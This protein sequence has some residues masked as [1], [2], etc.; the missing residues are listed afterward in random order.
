MNIQQEVVTLYTIGHSNRSIEEFVEILR[1]IPINTLVDV[2]A[3]PQSQRYPQFSQESLRQSLG[4]AGITYH[5]A[6]KQLGAM[7]KPQRESKHIALKDENLRAYADYM[8]SEVFQ[9]AMVQLIH[10]ASLENTV[11]LC[12][13]KLPEH[14]HR[15]LISDYLLLQGVE[16]RH[17]LDEATIVSHQLNP[18]V[19]RES[20]QL[21]YDRGATKSLDL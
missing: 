6:G 18:L 9:K 10:L 20:Q 12:A 2:R 7:R 14:C 11:I 17:I 3:Y 13:E 16:V 15:S 4:T 21:V 19:R 1:H 8:Q 5:W